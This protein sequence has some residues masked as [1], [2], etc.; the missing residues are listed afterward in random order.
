MFF[1]TKYCRFSTF[2][3]QPEAPYIAKFQDPH[4]ISASIPITESSN[5]AWDFNKSRN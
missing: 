4:V 2:Y 5:K 3:N 1:P